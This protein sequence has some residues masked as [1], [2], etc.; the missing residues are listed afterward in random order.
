MRESSYHAHRSSAAFCFAFS[1]FSP[2]SRPLAGSS[3]R[4]LPPQH[5]GLYSRQRIQL[6]ELADDPPARS[7]DV[8]TAAVRPQ[9]EEGA[10][11]GA[12]DP[13]P[14]SAEANL[15]NGFNP[16]CLEVFFS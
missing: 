14:A 15:V 4:P 6:E 11:D 9:P 7:A 1:H 12:P 8:G 16:I 2:S 5:G 13:P 10:S 3:L